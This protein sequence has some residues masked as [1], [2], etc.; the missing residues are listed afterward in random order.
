MIHLI[1]NYSMD[2]LPEKFQNVFGSP[3]D[4]Y[5]ALETLEESDIKISNKKEL[6]LL[7]PIVK[8]KK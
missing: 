4:L 2:N 8:A 7:I 5:E 6:I 3:I 1:A